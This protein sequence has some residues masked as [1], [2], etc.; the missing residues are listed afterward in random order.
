MQSVDNN[1]LRAAPTKSGL[2][3]RL[4]DFDTFVEALDYAATGATGMTYYNAK[5][6][7]IDLL[8]YEDLAVDARNV[9]RR[10]FWRQ[11]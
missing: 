10:A 9:S 5:G 8:T 11:V 7:V 1:M 3:F 6:E 4:A 2:P